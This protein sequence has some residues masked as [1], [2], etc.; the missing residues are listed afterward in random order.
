MIGPYE[1]AV[2]RLADVWTRTFLQQL[3]V[4]SIMCKPQSR[5]RGGR[6]W[7][8]PYG[9][10]QLCH[11]SHRS[12]PFG[13][14]SQN[15]VNPIK[16]VGSVGVHHGHAPLRTQFGTPTA[17]Q[18]V[19]QMDTLGRTAVGHRR[20]DDAGQHCTDGQ[21]TGRIDITDGQLSD[22]IDVYPQSGLITSHVPPLSVRTETRSPGQ[23]P[24]PHLTAR[25]S[26]G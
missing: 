23:A 1:L 16:P 22:I 5:S 17:L 4:L 15:T 25:S 13:T 10:D 11:R 8:S 12:H 26:Y 3:T 14:D 24:A 18:S 19:P 6:R 20:A 2:L 9:P 21:Q 7:S